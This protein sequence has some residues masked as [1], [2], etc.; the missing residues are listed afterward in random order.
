LVAAPALFP[1]GAPAVLL[2]A[3]E[4]AELAPA[5][6]LLLPPSEVS[7]PS[8]LLLPPQAASAITPISEK[9][10]FESMKAMS[11]SARAEW[12]LPA[13]QHAQGGSAPMPTL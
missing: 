6:L 5:V 9:P 12:S 10:S 13:T 4:P 7:P 11:S 8:E 2:S 1:L 3:G